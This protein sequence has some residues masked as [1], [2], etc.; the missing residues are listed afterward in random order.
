MTCCIQAVAL[1]A[2]LEAARYNLRRAGKLLMAHGT[3]GAD[4]TD[5][6][7]LQTLCNTAQIQHRAGRH[8]SAALSYANALEAAAKPELTAPLQ[9]CKELCSCTSC[10]VSWRRPLQ[11]VTDF[12][13]PEAVVQFAS[14]SDLQQSR[15]LPAGIAA[16]YVS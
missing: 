11:C 6:E 1:K 5:V 16:L 13:K 4:A 15:V 2:E 3:S 7:V 9:V 10:H 12:P 8:H 14:G